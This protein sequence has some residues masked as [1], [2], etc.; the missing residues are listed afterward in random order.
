[1]RPNG[2]KKKNFRFRL[3]ASF[4][5]TPSL[6]KITYKYNS[7]LTYIPVSFLF[8]FIFRVRVRVKNS[9]WYTWQ[10][11]RVDFLVF[12]ERSQRVVLNGAQSRF[13]PVDGTDDSWTS[14][15]HSSGASCDSSG[16]SVI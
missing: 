11:Q 4:K 14:G 16:A 6:R 10:D 9:I 8:S 15:V 12:T 3:W 5:S 2:P 13:L 1:M 7:M